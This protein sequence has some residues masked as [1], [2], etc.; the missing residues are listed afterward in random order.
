MRA[1]AE[2]ADDVAEAADGGER[3]IQAGATER[4]VD[5][6][7]PCAAGVSCDIVLHGL[8]RMVDRRC[9]DA[10]EIIA[11]GWPVDGIDLRAEGPGDLHD[12]MTDTAGAA[13]HK[14]LLA[15]PDMGAVDEALPGGHDGKRQNGRITERQIGRFACDQPCVHGGILG[16]R[17]L[18]AADAAGHAVDLVTRAKARDAHADRL[19][20]AGKIDAEHGGQGMARM[21]GGAGT[22]LGVERIDAAGGDADEHLARTGLRFGK[23]SQPE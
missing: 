7:E 3:G 10:A 4:V 11:L 1:P 13:E 16:Q 2:R 17:A 21:A 12:D 22:N 23:F 9:P 6:L 19:D 8:H 14:D 15:C 20:C 18:D 5:E